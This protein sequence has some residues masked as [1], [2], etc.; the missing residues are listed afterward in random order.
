MRYIKKYRHGLR[1]LA[2]CA[3]VI[4]SLLL[5]AYA[6]FFAA[7]FTD[8][9]RTFMANL[10]ERELAKEGLQIEIGE[11][12]GEAPSPLKISS[13]V[14]KDQKNVILDA[15]D[16]E[17]DWS[18][19]PLL[20]GE[21]H[22]QKLI[23]KKLRLGKPS[24]KPG[25]PSL[26]LEPPIL[27]FGLEVEQLKID[28]VDV[29][30]LIVSNQKH[31]FKVTA[32]HFGFGLVSQMWAGKL[33]IQE[34]NPEGAF[35]HFAMTTP[36]FG[37]DVDMHLKLQEKGKGVFTTLLGDKEPFEFDLKGSGK[38]LNWTGE[39]S[40]VMGQKSSVKADFAVTPDPRTQGPLIHVD[41][42]VDYKDLKKPFWQR[43]VRDQLNAKGSFAFKKEN[44]ILRHCDIASPFFRLKF[45]GDTVLNA[46]KILGAGKLH[47]SSKKPVYFGSNY[48]YEG[49]SE[50]DVTLQ[51]DWQKLALNMTG[52][53]GF[54]NQGEIKSL[55]SKIKAA[56]NLVDYLS[57]NQVIDFTADLTESKS[58]TTLPYA[59]D[60]ATL[61]G[62]G[63]YV[64][65]Q[66]R[67][68]LRDLN[69]KAADLELKGGMSLISGDVEGC[70]LKGTLHKVGP[71]ADRID[72][73]LSGAG[74]VAI[75]QEGL[76]DELNIT[77]ESDKIKADERPLDPLK[78]SV[79]FGQNDLLHIHVNYGDGKKPLFASA[80]FAEK[81]N[82]LSFREIKISDWVGEI[83]G[84]INFNKTNKTYEGRLDGS[85]ETIDPLFRLAGSKAGRGKFSINCG[86]TPRGEVTE[87]KA[88]LKVRQ[89]KMDDLDL[90]LGILNAN[91]LYASGAPLSGQLNTALFDG[92]IND[93][94][95]SE[96]KSDFRGKADNTKFDLE[97]KTLM[98][99]AVSFTSQGHYGH[100][101]EKHFLELDRWKGRI[102]ERQTELLKPAVFSWGDH[103]ISV[104]PL[105]FKMG[106]G[107]F[108]G[109]VK[110]NAHQTDIF[111]TLQNFPLAVI[112]MLS[113]DFPVEGNVT[114]NLQ[115]KGPSTQPEA[116]FDLVC[117]DLDFAMQEED[118]TKFKGNIK[119]KI[120]KSMMSL[121]GQVMHI[122]AGQNPLN[123]DFKAAMD[124]ETLWPRFGLQKP[125]H[126]G[127]KGALDLK[128]LIALWPFE[129]DALKG[130]L[131][132]DMALIGP[133]D[134]LQ[135]KGKASVA[136]GY[137]ENAEFGTEL[138]HLNFVL[139][140]RGQSVALTSFSGAARK[141]TLSAAGLMRL[142]DNYPYHIDIDLKD[143]PVV[144]NDDME[145]EGGGK[146]RVEGDAKL[147]DRITGK[148]ELNR[149][150][151]QL[152]QD[153]SPEL[154]DIFNLESEKEESHLSPRTALD[155]AISFKKPLLVKGWGIESSWHGDLSFKGTLETPALVGNLK[156]SQGEFAL[157]GPVFQLT[158][159]DIMFAEDAPM[160]PILS[161]KAETSEGDIKAILN[162]TG[163]ATAPR[164][165]LSS[166]PNLPQDEILSRILFREGTANLSPYQAVKI[167]H[168]IGK[169]NGAPLPLIGQL[170]SISSALGFD[171]FEIDAAKDGGT[172]PVVKFGKRISNTVKASLEEDVEK[173]KTQGKLQVELSPN[174]V[175]E[176]G[177]STDR[178]GSI[179]IVGK[180]EY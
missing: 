2:V 110:R 3:I 20:R 33:S 80:I 124:F 84:N 58:E 115:L 52:E 113:P 160:I 107:V 65:K 18:P 156:A 43:V 5:L 142:T 14:L 36:S 149:A 166:Q 117:D 94:R 77:L 164:I 140:G 170:E 168:L 25:T 133:M 145:I 40:A 23:I 139:E 12:T 57:A 15:E 26:S 69:F 144:M 134:A 101:D 157:F 71:L 1:I 179:G 103:E 100:D 67:M 59:L 151:Y 53:L 98:P 87:V 148:V 7:L 27:P 81:D 118:H 55:T 167:A 173:G 34:K 163:E 96:I 147:Q 112:Q 132:L 31:L 176:S 44:L 99:M 162:V 54:A 9:G 83:V 130:H 169:F 86:L 175:L 66:D 64:M 127:F 105:H 61:R 48:A 104:A 91:V 75:K 146:L 126:L 93:W 122:G 17:L 50:G 106:R 95:F 60:K 159:G 8:P 19:Y 180:W 111:A 136:G 46:Q 102:L 38:A 108:E 161:V 129:N 29:T 165:T 56:V 4:V 123:I 89:L 73:S 153:L 51:G 155:I 171:S 28:T 152:P 131:D 92:V 150:V 154:Q 72:L 74:K 178:D 11:I 158:Q 135:L 39:L 114:G 90:K 79:S 47:F 120:H 37:K 119:G 76:Q 137:Y 63:L 141:G 138:D 121:G 13:L 116:Q 42:N 82:V 41:M 24:D 49:V 45:E 128:D 97:V 16:I 68:D 10:V 125:I 172:S 85:I 35:V 62:S 88:L 143:Y 22:L 30:A 21:L 6:A 32:D 177:L 70:D 109:H 78:A 174:I